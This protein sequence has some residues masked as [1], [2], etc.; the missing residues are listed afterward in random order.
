VP[1]QWLVIPEALAKAKHV[2]STWQQAAA[3]LPLC[4]AVIRLR[5]GTYAIR[6]ASGRPA[7]GR[8]PYVAFARL[9][10]P[11]FEALLDRGMLRAVRVCEGWFAPV[12][13]L[14]HP[15]EGERSNI[16]YPTPNHQ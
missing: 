11:V 14:G 8:L 2:M 13:S 4:G 1:A 10:K 16:Q 5:S 6:S 7:T 9:A 3:V 15:H 12:C